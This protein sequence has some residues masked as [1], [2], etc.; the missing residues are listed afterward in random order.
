MNDLNVDIERIYRYLENIKDSDKKTKKSPI[1]YLIDIENRLNEH[2]RDIKYIHDQGEE[3]HVKVKARVDDRRAAKQA[4][5]REKINAA[6]RAAKMEAQ[7]KLVAKENLRVKKFG[8]PNTTRSA[9]PKMKQKVVKR[10]ID[11]ETQDEL[12]YLGMEL[13]DFPDEATTNPEEPH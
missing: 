10:V 5:A 3:F 7:A 2:M 6:E 11:P 12:N 1:Q 4:E 9:K 8:K 13:K